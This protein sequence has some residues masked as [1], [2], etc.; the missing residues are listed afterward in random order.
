MKMGR[1]TG[2]GKRGYKLP[3]LMI[4]SRFLLQDKAGDTGNHLISSI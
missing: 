3:P 4:F 1:N 2:F